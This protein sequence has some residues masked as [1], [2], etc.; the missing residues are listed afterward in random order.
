M[1]PRMAEVV[2]ATRAQRCGV[3][4]WRTPSQQSAKIVLYLNAKASSSKKV[5]KITAHSSSG[6]WLEN[7]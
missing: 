1:V 5:F 2:M 4:Q 3:A 7:Q 6:K